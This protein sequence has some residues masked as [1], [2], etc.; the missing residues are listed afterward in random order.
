[1]LSETTYDLHDCRLRV[2]QKMGHISWNSL[3]YTTFLSQYDRAGTVL[4]PPLTLQLSVRL[5]LM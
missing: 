3:I 2:V 1:M 4:K 5:Y